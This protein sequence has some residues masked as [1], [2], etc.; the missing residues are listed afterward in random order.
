MSGPI[1]DAFYGAYEAQ[2]ADDPEGHAM[3]YI[4]ILMAIE[5]E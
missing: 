1:V 2:V 3:D 4:H 5:K